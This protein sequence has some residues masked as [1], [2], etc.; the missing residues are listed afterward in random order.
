MNAAR[1]LTLPVT[2]GALP[3]VVMNASNASVVGPPE[4]TSSLAVLSRIE[5]VAEAVWLPL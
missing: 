5:F 3:F 1:V 4:L 2:V